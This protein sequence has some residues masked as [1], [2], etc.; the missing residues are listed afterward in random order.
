MGFVIGKSARATV[1]STLLPT[2]SDTPLTHSD[3]V[4]RQHDVM[5][6]AQ[7]SGLDTLSLESRLGS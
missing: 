2:T 4:G 1:L 7:M 3:V 6:K 5:E